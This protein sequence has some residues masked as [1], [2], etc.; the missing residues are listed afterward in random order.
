MKYILSRMKPEEVK[1]IKCYIY[2]KD[3]VNGDKVQSEATVAD[4]RKYMEYGD[5]VRRKTIW[6]RMKKAKEAF[7]HYWKSYDIDGY[8]GIHSM[9][10]YDKMIVYIDENGNKA[11]KRNK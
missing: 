4:I 5:T 2:F 6:K 3:K 7:K 11:I 8:N 9:Q 10:D 1:L